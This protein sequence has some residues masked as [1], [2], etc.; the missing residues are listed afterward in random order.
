LASP[1]FI[2]ADP[3]A[4]VAIFAS[5]LDLASGVVL[6][7]V[8]YESRR[9]IMIPSEDFVLV[10]DDAIERV[11]HSHLSAVEYCESVVSHFILL[12]CR[13]VKLPEIAISY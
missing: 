11:V 3:R 8:T 2:L 5:N 12:L 1:R 6:G 7:I 13:R 4:P 10:D 9:L